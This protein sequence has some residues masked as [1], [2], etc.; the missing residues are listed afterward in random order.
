MVQC[1]LYGGQ[2]AVAEDVY[3]VALAGAVGAY[4][5][6]NAGTLNSF[7]QINENGLTGLVRGLS[8]SSLA[9]GKKKRKGSVSPQ[10]LRDRSGNAFYGLFAG[11]FLEDGKGVTV[12]G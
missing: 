11:L 5:S 3:S 2:A 12:K 9:R 6:F 10:S 1:F 8:F 4:V 7:T